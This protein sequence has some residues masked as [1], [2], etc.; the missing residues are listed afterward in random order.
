MAS[1][2]SKTNTKFGVYKS[3]RPVRF[4]I[5]I[6]AFR[7]G[8]LNIRPRLR[9]RGKSRESCKSLLFFLSI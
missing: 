1:N 6:P 2:N 9:H 3:L 7:L 4:L 8:Q 5:L